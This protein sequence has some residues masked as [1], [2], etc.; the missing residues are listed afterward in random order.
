MATSEPQAGRMGWLCPRCGSENRLADRACAVCLKQPAAIYRWLEKRRASLEKRWFTSGS[1]DPALLYWADDHN[2]VLGLWVRR[3]A[4][5]CAALALAAALAGGLPAAIGKPALGLPQLAARADALLTRPPLHLQEL[6][7]RPL[8]LMANL[9]GGEPLGARALDS[10]AARWQEFAGSVIQ[11]KAA[12]AGDALRAS[13]A[14]VEADF[15]A[16]LSDRAGAFLENLPRVQR[17]VSQHTG[18]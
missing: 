6:A 10:L 2:R 7:I 11:G 4:L 13:A 1:R 5:A 12:R 14:L 18:L 9:R 16:W 8:R 17:W 3:F 15:P